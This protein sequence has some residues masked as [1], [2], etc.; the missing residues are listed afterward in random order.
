ML[1]PL[2]LLSPTHC[3]EYISPSPP[4]LYLCKICIGAD[5]FAEMA[6]GIMSEGNPGETSTLIHQ[7]LFQGMPTYT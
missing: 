5:M 7:T 3:Q 4:S 6:D 2:Q 1:I